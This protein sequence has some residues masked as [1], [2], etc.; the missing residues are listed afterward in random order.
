MFWLHACICTMYASDLH[1]TI[2]RGSILWKW[3]Y[4]R[5]TATMWVLGT[6]PRSPARASILNCWAIFLHFIPHIHSP[7]G[8]Q[9]WKQVRG[10]S[11]FKI[12]E[13]NNKIIKSLPASHCLAVLELPVDQAGLSIGLKACTIGITW[14]NFPKSLASLVVSIWHNLSGCG[15]THL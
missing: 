6:E 11:L 14:S 1:K 4:R 5:L 10:P 12:S 8:S 13:A 9:L 15:S 2:R 3:N 7:W